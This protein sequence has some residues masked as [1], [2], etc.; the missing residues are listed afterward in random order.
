MWELCFESVGGLLWHFTYCK[1]PHTSSH[2][3]LLRRRSPE[4]QN[5]RGVGVFC[6]KAVSLVLTGRLAR[7]QLSILPLNMHNTNYSWNCSWAMFLETIKTIVCS[8]TQPHFIVG[9][10]AT[11]LHARPFEKALKIFYWR[12]V[13]PHL[14][15]VCRLLPSSQ[16]HHELL[17]G[18]VLQWIQTS[19]ER[20]NILWTEWLDNPALLFC[21]KPH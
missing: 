19:F 9:A 21:P 14:H 1:R 8:A 13:Y 12:P 11:S 7:L 20:L 15:V 10:F 5:S 6:R 16:V 2:K 18:Y 3:C 17:V 4:R